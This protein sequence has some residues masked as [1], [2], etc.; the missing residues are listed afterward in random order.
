MLRPYLFVNQLLLAVLL[1]KVNLEPLA[2][3]PK[4][5]DFLRSTTEALHF[6]GPSV[7]SR[8]YGSGLGVY[9]GKSLAQ[10]LDE[11]K[12]LLDRDYNV[13]LYARNPRADR[14][15]AFLRPNRDLED[16]VLSQ[17]HQGGSHEFQ[18]KPCTGTVALSGFS[19]VFGGMG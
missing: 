1:D 8:V 17:R 7:A 5:P 2:R 3:N 14:R 18:S 10:F 9:I 6:F 15:R 12:Q 16:P 19:V 13:M 11:Y 4:N